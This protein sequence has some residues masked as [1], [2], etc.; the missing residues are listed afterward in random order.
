MVLEYDERRLCLRTWPKAARGSSQGVTSGTLEKWG[1]VFATNQR[2]FFCTGQSQDT[3]ETRG[4]EVLCVLDH[5]LAHTVSAHSG[6]FA[7]LARTTAAQR[8]AMSKQSFPELSAVRR[9]LVSSDCG[10]WIWWSFWWFI[11]VFAVVIPITLL[12]SIAIF[13]HSVT[14]PNRIHCKI[15]A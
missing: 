12:I 4:A 1:V 5:F 10:E 7:W 15:C 14:L 9:H 11:A 6:R 8:H 2:A 3:H 13:T